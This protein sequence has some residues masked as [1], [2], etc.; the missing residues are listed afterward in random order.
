[1]SLHITLPPAAGWLVP[2]A[3][4]WLGLAGL[5]PFVAGALATL[6]ISGALRPYGLPLLLYYGAIILSFMGGVHWGAAMMRDD[7]GFGP[8]G[9]SVASAL[10]ALPAALIGG[11][12][13]LM[14]LSAGFLGL[15][16]YDERE[17]QGRRLPRW[18]PHLRR[19][20]TAI[21][22]T[23]LLIGAAAQFW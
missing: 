14:L 2:P 7:P 17:T 12:A 4:R 10:I 8:L 13:G 15:L 3:A 20:L 6:P 19:P 21:V 22:T 1:M 18:Y 23:C 16:I 11:A 9:R 5:I